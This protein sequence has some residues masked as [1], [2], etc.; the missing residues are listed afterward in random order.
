MVVL[1]A[2]ISKLLKKTVNL[3]GLS[4]R[5]RSAPK[6]LRES[7]KPRCSVPP[8]YREC[9]V[10]EIRA[11]PF[12]ANLT[13]PKNGRNRLQKVEY[14]TFLL[15]LWSFVQFCHKFRLEN[16]SG[17]I[18]F[19][20]PA[21][22]P[23][24]KFSQDASQNKP[25]QKPEDRKTVYSFFRL[26]RSWERSFSSFAVFPGS[27]FRNTSRTYSPRTAETLFPWDAQ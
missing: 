11:G 22:G 25:K 10:Q 12:R 20:V 18:V 1:M 6:T 26:S 5:R 19:S 4:K 24:G 23:P 14:S 9:A 15:Y 17:S 3:Q 13:L 8:E 2:T 16:G 27:A 7:R 21:H